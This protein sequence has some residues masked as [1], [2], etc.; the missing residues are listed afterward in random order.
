[1]QASGNHQMQHEPKLSFEADG[2]ALADPAHLPSGPALH[3]GEGGAGGAQKKRAR[4]PNAFEG[5]AHDPLFQRFHV[6]D[7]VRQFGHPSQV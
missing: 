3:L 2:D 7:D 1:M 6:H 4:Q 5:P